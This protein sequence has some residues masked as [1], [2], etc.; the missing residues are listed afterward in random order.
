MQEKLIIFLPADNTHSLEWVVLDD[1][2]TVKAVVTG[3]DFAE[4]KAQV[5]D[6]EVIAVVPAQDVLL[7]SLSLPKMSRAKLSQAVPFALEDK[8]IEDVE[9]MHFAIAEQHANSELPVAV[10]SKDNMQ[11]WLASFA[12]MHI[13]PDVILPSVFA[14][15]F[16]E[17]NWQVIVDD[18][19]IVRTGVSSGF[20]CDAINLDQMLSLALNEAKPEEIVLTHVEGAS[21]SLDLP[22]PVTVNV[23]TKDELL[24]EMAKTVV[25]GAGVNLLQ[26]EFVNK[27]SKRMPKM[28][29]LIKSTG[30]LFIF[31]LFLLLAY[32]VVSYV[33][34]KRATG[35]VHDE[36]AMIYKKHFPTAKHVIAPKQRLQQKLAKV[37]SSLSENQF[38][39]ILSGIGVGLKKSPDVVLKRVD[40]QGNL[41]SVEVSA[42]SS[43][44]ITNFVKALGRQGFNVK[45]QSADL[46]EAGVTATLRVE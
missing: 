13:V 14:L 42:R 7:I 40:Y 19:A 3:G 8:L 4:V 33:M 5:A 21:V 24:A 22:V 45:E 38:L 30:Y 9:Q 6:R 35:N 15:P 1:S 27:K 2:A 34:L 41:A 17:N 29:N 28:S 31:W 43:D 25:L 12:E 26:G 16:D 39:Q 32:P 37:Q 44:L 18:V 11:D 36:I 23:L 20:A 46:S 10:V